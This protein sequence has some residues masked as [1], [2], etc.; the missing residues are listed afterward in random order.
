MDTWHHGLEEAEPVNCLQRGLGR[1]AAWPGLAWPGGRILSPLHEPNI[2]ALSK[3]TAN[4]MI[5]G[6]QSK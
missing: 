1:P 4:L 5:T 3:T 2:A 6:F